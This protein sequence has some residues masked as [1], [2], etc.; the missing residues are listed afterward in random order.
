MLAAACDWLSSHCISAYKFVSMSGKL[1]HDRSPLVLDSD[2]LFCAVTA[3]FHRLHQ[4]FSTF[5]LKG[6]KPRPT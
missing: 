1:N 5:S 2:K 6:T 4:W 3:P